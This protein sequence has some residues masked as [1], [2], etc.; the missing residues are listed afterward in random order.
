ML[1]VLSDP[2]LLI[3]SLHL[4]SSISWSSYIFL[5]NKTKQSL[6]VFWACKICLWVNC[7]DPLRAL[8]EAVQDNKKR[9]PIVSLAVK[10]VAGNSHLFS[11]Y[12]RISLHNF[13]SFVNPL[14]FTK[15]E[16][17]ILLRNQRSNILASPCSAVPAHYTAMFCS[18]LLQPSAHGGAE[19]SCRS[20][21]SPCSAK[22]QNP[23][24][25]A[26]H[27][28]QQSCQSAL[29]PKQA[30][31]LYEALDNWKDHN[32]KGDSRM[33]NEHTARKLK[34]EN[35]W[36]QKIPRKMSVKKG[37]GMVCKVVI[38]VALWQTFS[39]PA[40]ELLG[41][42]LTQGYTLVA[43]KGLDIGQNVLFN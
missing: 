19:Q 6:V 41:Q 23:N 42:E 33:N 1:L 21:S 12:R 30:A 35:F 7:T 5:K 18:S 26:L 10:L 24:P 37:K 14:L 9:S 8:S 38:D 25:G 22:K 34:C 3:C 4:V 28:T 15:I 17:R 20:C 2:P 11:L 36:E 13:A 27:T 16:G 43:C 32:W 29:C 40:F 39:N 31:R